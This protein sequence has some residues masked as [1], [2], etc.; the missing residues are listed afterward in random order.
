MKISSRLASFKYRLAY[1]TLLYI[2]KNNSRTEAYKSEGLKL[3]AGKVAKLPEN[4]AFKP[5][6][7]PKS[8]CIK[9][10]DKLY[11]FISK[12]NLK[13]P[14]SERYDSLFHEVGHWLHFQD[15]PSLSERKVIWQGV[16]L[17][18]ICNDVSQ[19]AACDSKEFVAEVF[20][21]LVKGKIFDEYIMNLYKKLK[22]PE[23]K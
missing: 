8:S 15:M 9:A 2:N 19:R 20:K 6:F 18:K 14:K 3:L 4:I 23:V 21:W 16:N 22:G 12:S 11:I 13:K 17:D 1:K 10:F 5:S 7:T